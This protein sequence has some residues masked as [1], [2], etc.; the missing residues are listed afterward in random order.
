MDDYLVQCYPRLP[1]RFDRG[2]GAWLWDT[3]GRRYLDAISGLAVCG[4]GH[5]HPAVTRAVSEQ[6]AW[7]VHTSNL[8]G[9]DAQA[10]LAEGL[11]T[12]SGLD[13]VFFCNSGT[14]ANEAAIKF[15]R[16]WARRRGNTTPV[17]ITMEGGFHGRTLG[18]LA[19]TDT[20]TGALFGP[21][22][23]GFV[24]VPFNSVAKVEYALDKHPQACAVMVEPIQGENGVILGGASY[25]AAL[26]RM[27]DRFGVLLIIDE[28]QTGMGRTGAW[29]YCH[30]EN[31]RPDILTTAKALG[32]GV[33]I[34][35][36]LVDEG[37]AE[38]LEPGMHGSTFGGNPLA[39]AAALAVL[40]TMR[41]ESLCARAA[42][43]GRILLDRLCA[44][45]GGVEGIVAIRGR[46]MMLGIE[47]DGPVEPLARQALDRGL[48]VNVTSKRVV[49][50][51]PPL[52]LD[53]EQV[54][55]IVATLTELVPYLA[56]RKP[57]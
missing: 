22:P 37:V 45:F 23:G 25:L 35:A 42:E 48:L 57:P 2:D 1:V 44:N 20:E 30:H 55:I 11:A 26:R 32:N 49:R 40:G 8:Y 6:A 9:I 53:H 3:D 4:L 16:L 10:E 36:C 43:M 34:G 29:Y 31:V 56:D 50:L 14:E 21:L 5:A 54:D 24:R 19:A 13:R 12:I 46:G 7:L 27:C 38:C 39:C 15:A 52:I 51:L 18:S 17:I 47:F 28:I 33:P 41:A